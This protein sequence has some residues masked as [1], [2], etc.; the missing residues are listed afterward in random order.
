MV[1]KGRADKDANT[2]I[3][4]SVAPVSKITLDW[5]LVD[6]LTEEAEVNDAQS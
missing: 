2:N 1:K 5:L 4:C 3:L 6:I